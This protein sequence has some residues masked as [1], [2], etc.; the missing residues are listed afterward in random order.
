MLFQISFDNARVDGSSSGTWPISERNNS[1]MVKGEI[2]SLMSTG[3]D[4]Q[5]SMI[6]GY[7]QEL[8]YRYMDH[9]LPVKKFFPVLTCTIARGPSHAARVFAEYMHAVTSRRTCS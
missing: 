7:S 8:K 1:R 6:D 9:Q 4:S 5:D 3:F 2:Q